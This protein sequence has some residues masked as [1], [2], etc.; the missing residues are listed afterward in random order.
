MGLFERM[1]ETKEV[2][3]HHEWDVG[4]SKS[5]S[6]ETRLKDAR[7]REEGLKLSLDK[8][9]FGK[10]SV[11]FVGHMLSQEGIATDPSK[12]EAAIS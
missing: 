11:I 4:L 3:S 9:Q 1:M 12:V 6:R 10:T 8:C 5:T 7:L 2:F